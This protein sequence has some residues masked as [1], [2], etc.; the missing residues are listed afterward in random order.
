MIQPTIGRQV[1]F[2]GPIPELGSR[3][4]E[5]ATVCY[6]HTDR[7]VNLHVIDHN[8]HARPIAEVQLRQPED[9][10]PQTQFC[11]WM[12]YQKRQAA[13]AEQLEKAGAVMIEYGANYSNVPNAFPRDPQCPAIHTGREPIARVCHE[14]NRALCQAFGDFSQPSWDAAPQWQRD[15]ALIGV[16]LHLGN[17][18][19]GPEASH[20]SWMA[21]KREAGWRYGA[22]KD[23][24][25]KTHP[26]MVEFSGLPPEQQAKD[27]VFRAIVHAM[28]LNGVDER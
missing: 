17:Q 4:P 3:Q 24:D 20:E 23:V 12:P 2:W 16:D 6:V 26:C 14:A 22:V 5:A 8:G 18:D 27:F 25:A 9:D 15:S 10:V 7:L 11:E 13:E 21:H 28:R 1:W 19:L